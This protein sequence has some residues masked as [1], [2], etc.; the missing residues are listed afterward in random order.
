MVGGLFIP[1]LADAGAMEEVQLCV[2]RAVT[3]LLSLLLP[4]YPLFQ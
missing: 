1:M 2:R 3:G 4:S